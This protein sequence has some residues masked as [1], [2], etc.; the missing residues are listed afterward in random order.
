MN[1]EVRILNKLRAY[2]SEVRI[3]KSLAFLLLGGWCF[4]SCGEGR[5][6]GLANKVRDYR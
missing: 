1:L 2:F 6:E 4:P 5:R 3:L